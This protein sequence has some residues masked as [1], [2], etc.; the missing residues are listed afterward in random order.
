MYCY[1]TLPHPLKIIFLFLTLQI[2]AAN[3]SAQSNSIKISPLNFIDYNTDLGY[4]RMF[5]NKVSLGG[6]LQFWF[7]DKGGD[8]VGKD[9]YSLRIHEGIR[10]SL[11]VRKYF[12]KKNIIKNSDFNCGISIHYGKH[13]VKGIESKPPVII[14]PTRYFDRYDTFVLSKGI[15]FHFVYRL[16]FK[17]GLFTNFELIARN[18]WV[19]QEEDIKY[20]PNEIKGVSFQPRF[21]IGYRF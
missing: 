18:N 15:G 7:K 8:T 1:K 19:D 11:V 12:Y 16:L 4:E 14:G 17:D 9:I 2:I 6:S 10:A 5:K 3:I 21:Q 13:F 20:F